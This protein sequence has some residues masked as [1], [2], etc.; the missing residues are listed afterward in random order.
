MWVPSTQPITGGNPNYCKK[1][2]VAFKKIIFL[3]WGKK[4]R[5]TNIFTYQNA[6]LFLHASNCTPCYPKRIS[7]HFH[8]ALILQILKSNSQPSLETQ[9]VMT[10]FCRPFPCKGPGSIYKSMK[11]NFRHSE[12]VF[13]FPW[14]HF[15]TFHS[16]GSILPL[17]IFFHHSSVLPGFTQIF[18]FFPTNLKQWK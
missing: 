11:I 8:R 4:K 15:T 16:P 1:Q 18:M 5:W 17:F 2:V 9:R 10:N 7:C 13:P 3:G 14:I 6:D 12:V